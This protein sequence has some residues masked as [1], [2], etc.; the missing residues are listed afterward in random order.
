MAGKS[1]KKPRRIAFAMTKGGAGKT[2][3]AAAVATELAERG[4]KVLLVDTDAQALVR[5]AL[6]ALDSTFGLYDLADGEPFENVVYKFTDHEDSPKQRPGLNLIVAQG[7]LS[8]LATAWTRADEDLEG[9]FSDL[10]VQVEEKND[11]DYILVDCSPTAGMMNT[12]VLYYVH[13]IF[14]PVAI[15]AFHVLGLEDFLDLV[16]TTRKKKAKRRDFE[17][18]IKYVLPT[19]LNLTKRSTEVL[20]EKVKETVSLRLPAAKLLQPIPECART[21]EC[22]IYGQSIIEYEKSSRGGK[23]YLQVVEE[24]IK[25]GIQRPREK[26]VGR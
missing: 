22:A 19:R 18:E 7:N 16:E 25:D 17:L 15:S 13:E 26:A 2:T 21:D 3:S 8:K 10:M 1:K 20:Y 12:N 23:A 4:Y 9:F 6:G 5:H 14:L 11:Y 24:I